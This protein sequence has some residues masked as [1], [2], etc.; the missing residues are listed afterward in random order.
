MTNYL[1][2]QYQSILI[3][4][5]SIAYETPRKTIYYSL[6]YLFYYH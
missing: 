3:T 6:P 2:L 4:H 5:S 1:I